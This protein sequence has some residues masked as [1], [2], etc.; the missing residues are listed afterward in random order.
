MAFK[1]EGEEMYHIF[2]FAVLLASS[3][4]SGKAWEA[5]AQQTEKPIP[6]KLCSFM[7]SLCACLAS[8][9]SIV[10]FVNIWFGVVQHQ[11]QFGFK[12]GRKIG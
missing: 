6:H 5:C 9:A 1:I 8:S 3:L 12:E 10:Y 2:V 7:S 4:Q 11:K